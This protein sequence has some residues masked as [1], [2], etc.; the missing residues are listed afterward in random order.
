MLKTFLLALMVVCFSFSLSAQD[1]WRYIVS[2]TI[3]KGG[4]E[5]KLFNNMYTQQTGGTSGDLTD[6]STFFTSNLSA[7]YGLN[8]RINVGLDIKYRRV[9]YANASDAP[10]A[11]FG[12]LAAPSGRRAFTGIGPKVRVAPFTSLPNFSVQSTLWLAP[13]SDQEGNAQESYIDWNKAIWW[14]QFFNDFS[15]NDQMAIFAEVDF[16]W[17][18]IGGEETDFNRVSTPVTAI[19]S[20]FPVENLTLYGMAGYSPYWQKDYDYFYQGG[21]G[22]KYQLHPDFEIEMLY[23]L[24]SNSYL[25]FVEGKA[26]T[27]NVGFRYSKF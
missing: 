3:P 17:E 6:R 22:V 24:F 10:F 12:G 19:F 1:D 23:T 15:L 16:L 7:L 14:T 8:N 26:T 11:V 9:L 21:V 5:L 20:Y 27:F 25:E 18:D 2:S 13:G 4:V